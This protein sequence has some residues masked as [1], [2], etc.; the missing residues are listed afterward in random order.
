M[1]L[2]GRSLSSWQVACWAA[3]AL[4]LL[5]LVL[6]SYPVPLGFSIFFAWTAL[7]VATVLGKRMALWAVLCVVPLGILSVDWLRGL[8]LNQD[9]FG[10]FP[11]GNIALFCGVAIVTMAT[12]TLSILRAALEQK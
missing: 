5:P 9:R 3:A 2:F 8:G 12:G 10:F 4:V 1:N 7:C 6:P 11:W